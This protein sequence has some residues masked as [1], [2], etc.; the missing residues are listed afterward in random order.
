MKRISHRQYLAYHEW[1]FRE[2]NRADKLDRYLMRICSVLG[3]GKE[4]DYKV[5]FKRVDVAGS[6]E[7]PITLTEAEKKTLS[8]VA[9]GRI[10]RA[11]GA[12]GY[13]QPGTPVHEKPEVGPDGKVIPTAR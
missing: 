11:I 5:T 1:F 4:G 9:R 7:Q 10:G 12:A 8:A 6:V 13:V 2:D 3:G